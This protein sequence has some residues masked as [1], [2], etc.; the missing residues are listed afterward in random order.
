MEIIGYT[1][2]QGDDEDVPRLVNRAI[3]EGWVPQGGISHAIDKDYD[4]YFTQA[5]V[6]YKQSKKPVKADDATF[7]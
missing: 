7:E 1:I 6:K 4:H 3:Q 5:M 2:I